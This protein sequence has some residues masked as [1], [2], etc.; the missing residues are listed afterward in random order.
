MNNEVEAHISLDEKAQWTDVVVGYQSRVEELEE[1][2]REV[3]TLLTNYLVQEKFL[4][5]SDCHEVRDRV[6]L[7]LKKG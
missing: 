4:Y 7:A 5:G 1:V 6:R 2:L 3:D